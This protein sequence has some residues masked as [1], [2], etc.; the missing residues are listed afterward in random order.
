MEVELTRAQFEAAAAAIR[1]RTPQQP[2]IGLVL[3][4]G[5]GSLAEAVGQADSIPASDI[6]H[7]PGSTVEGHVGR[8]VIGQLEGQTVL[9]QQGR[10]HHYEGHSMQRVTLPI[11]VMQLLGLEAVIVTNAAGAINPDF[12]PGDVMLITDHIN[13]MGMAGVSP[14]RGPNEASFGPRFPDMSQAYDRGLRSLALEVA[15]QAGLTLYQG[16]YVCLGGPSFETPADLRFLRLIGADAVGMSTVPE[17]TVA[18]HGGLRVLGFSGISNAA[19]LDGSTTTTH[20]EVLAAGQNI[21]PKLTALIRGVL[22]QWPAQR[23][24]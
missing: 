9:V 10:A 2:R 8:V 20:E 24:A 14:L 21:V 17:V 1:A 23:Q 7:W 22:R 15:A 5:L 6:P 16:V 11:R 18:R 13:F 3:G 4:S 19:N 12:R